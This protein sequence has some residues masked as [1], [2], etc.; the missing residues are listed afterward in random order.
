M[1]GMVQTRMT[2]DSHP[3]QCRQSRLRQGLKAT[4]AGVPA[5]SC[6]TS[7]RREFSST[8]AYWRPGADSMPPSGLP[9][10]ASQTPAT[11]QTCTDASALSSMLNAKTNHRA[12]ERYACTA[13][14]VDSRAAVSVPYQAYVY[15]AT[16]PAAASLPKP[17]PLPSPTAAT[18]YRWTA[19][20]CCVLSK[21][22]LTAS[23][24]YSGCTAVM[25]SPS[26]HLEAE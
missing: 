21:R 14:H 26:R 22:S 15:L 13:I 7:Q 8:G 5:G 1:T 17:L 20:G 16:R 10:Q 9:W 2:C 11:D 25:S 19:L 3:L 18:T 24:T 6:R 23:T 12:K 4:T